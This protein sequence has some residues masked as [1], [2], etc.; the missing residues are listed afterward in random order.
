MFKFIGKL[1]SGGNPL[2]TIFKGIDNL[3]T[4]DEEKGELRLRAISLSLK[5]EEMKF[6]DK[7]DARSMYKIDS[8][9]QKVFAIIFLISYMSII[10]LFF[11]KIFGGLHLEQWASNFVFA[12][13][14]GMSAKVNTIV[15]FLFGGSTPNNQPH[16]VDKD[17]F[18]KKQKK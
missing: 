6:T 13:F 2:E 4:S 15:D 18:D 14:G 10:G 1:F 5:K 12:I 9:L 8:S 7:A 3:V 16:P 17:L 11:W